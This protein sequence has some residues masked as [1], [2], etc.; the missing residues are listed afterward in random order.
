MITESFGCPDNDDLI[1]RYKSLEEV[2]KIFPDIVIDNVVRETRWYGDI[3][4]Y[5]LRRFREDCY[6]FIPFL[7][8]KDIDGTRKRQ[9]EKEAV[10]A[11]LASYKLQSTNLHI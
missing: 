4:F 2:Q 7:V 1:R 9:I 3:V 5:T 10:T 6:V 11:F 8:D